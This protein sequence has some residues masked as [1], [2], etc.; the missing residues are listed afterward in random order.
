MDHLWNW[1]NK[2]LLMENFSSGYTSQ[3]N[4]N[5]LKMKLDRVCD[6]EV[7]MPFCWQTI[8]NTAII[9]WWKDY[10]TKATGSKFEILQTWISM[11]AF[12]F[13]EQLTFP[14]VIGLAII[15]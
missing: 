2:K 6:L 3:L 12:M 15:H 11:S 10:N 9:M 7:T 5:A 1:Y 13:W 8:N 14:T 4:E